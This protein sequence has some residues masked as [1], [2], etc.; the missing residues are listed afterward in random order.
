MHLGPNILYTNTNT[1]T[2]VL[3]RSCV[4]FASLTCIRIHLCAYKF[5]IIRK[6]S[7][8]HKLKSKFE[9]SPAARMKLNQSFFTYTHTFTHIHINVY[10]DMR[11]A[12]KQPEP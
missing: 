4:L 9:N 8:M 2:H 10:T 7:E 11:A 3:I 6:P 5:I 12:D 1:L